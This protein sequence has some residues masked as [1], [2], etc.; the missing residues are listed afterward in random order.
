MVALGEVA[1]ARSQAAFHATLQLIHARPHGDRRHA[2]LRERE[3]VG[4]VEEPRLEITIAGIAAAFG[5]GG[6]GQ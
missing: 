5:L 6:S 2:R 3:M 1:G 4:A